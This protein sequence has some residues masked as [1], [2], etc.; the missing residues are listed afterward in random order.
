[1]CHHAACM[2]LYSKHW[3]LMCVTMH[4]QQLTVV[5]RA[6]VTSGWHFAGWQLQQHANLTPQNVGLHH[7]EPEFVVTDQL[8]LDNSSK[9]AMQP[10]ATGMHA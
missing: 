7:R 8:Y 9:R 1:M 2:K 4:K 10:A 5:L 3:L 6:V